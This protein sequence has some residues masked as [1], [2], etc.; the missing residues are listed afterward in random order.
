MTLSIQRFEP[1]YQSSVVKLIEHIQVGEFDIPISEG[2]RQELQTI[3]TVFQKDKGN[4]WVAISSEKVIGTMAVLDIGHDALALRDVFVHEDYRGKEK[5]FAKQLLDTVLRWAKEHNIKTIYLGTT[6][7]FQA[8]HRFYEKHGFREISKTTLPSY[9]PVM[10][11]D[12]K[13]YQLDL[14]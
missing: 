13:F 10:E 4:Y 1:K 14:T 3:P 12:E 6:L 5:G 8:A 9:F 2:Q 11:V 7:A